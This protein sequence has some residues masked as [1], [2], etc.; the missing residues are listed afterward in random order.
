LL[1]SLRELKLGIRTQT[2][3]FVFPNL[4]S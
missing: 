2:R 4:A 1:V 3:F